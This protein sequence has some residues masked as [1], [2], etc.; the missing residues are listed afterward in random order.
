MIFLDQIKPARPRRRNV[1]CVAFMAS[2][3]LI[4]L[5]LAQ[6]I[7]VRRNILE[8]DH[9]VAPLQDIGS[10]K[11]WELLQRDDF[12]F[13]AVVTFLTASPGS[14]QTFNIPKNWNSTQVGP[15]GF[16][17]KIETVA[18][19]GS[20]GAISVSDPVGGTIVGGGGGAYSA[21]TNLVLVP[22]STL[23]YQIGVGGAAI[24]AAF[25]TTGTGNPGGDSWFNAT[26]LAAS[27]VGAKGGAGGHAAVSTLTAGSAGGAAAS[28]I[29]STKHSGGASGS[30]TTSG[31]P[32]S[33]SGGGGA[34]GPNGDGN[35]SANAGISG[36]TAGGSADAGSGGAGGAGNT[37]GSGTAG[38]SGTEFDGSHGCG[39]GG[40]AGV[41]QS[42]A[43]VNGGNGGLYG[44]GGG[45]QG[46]GTAGGIGTALSGAGAQGLIVV[47]NVVATRVIFS[48]M[49]G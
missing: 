40:G 49:V 9:F 3:T 13:L 37:A 10:G 26:T 4:G 29:G 22:G 17:N 39:G 30:A 6:G 31:D 36:A 33:A 35:A 25:E 42:G 23:T 34:G 47:T 1:Q 14:N 5:M 2:A 7:R 38:S 32:V 12:Q 15:A 21:I 8:T 19:G 41:S 16:A 43:T 11:L 46:A 18:G 27:S 24:T 20:G 44:G 45:G 28:G 48:G